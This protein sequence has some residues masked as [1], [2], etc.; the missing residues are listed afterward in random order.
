MLGQ[1]ITW[2]HYQYNFIDLG[3]IKHAGYLCG[4]PDHLCIPAKFVSRDRAKYY[5][6]VFTTCPVIWHRFR[7]PGILILV[8]RLHTYKQDHFLSY[9]CQELSP[10]FIFI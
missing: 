3:E 6:V 10:M 7:P 5:A 9:L 4:G 1:R 8:A 2:R